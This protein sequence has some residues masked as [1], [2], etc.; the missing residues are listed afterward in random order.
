MK[1]AV[2]KNP[3]FGSDI[4]YFV[5]T[6]AAGELIPIIGM[7]GG[8]KDQPK[9]LSDGFFVQEDNVALEFNIPICKT[10]KDFVSA[11][12]TGVYLTKQALP[13]GVVPSSMVS[14]SFNPAYLQHPKAMEFGCEPDFNAWT[15]EVNPRPEA[16]DKTLRSCGGH[17]HV[18]WDNPDINTRFE[19][20]K[21]LDVFVGLN[22]LT[23]D[24]DVGRRQLYGK[25]GAMR[26]KEYGMEYRTLS[27][28]WIWDE[29]ITE[30]VYNGIQKAIDFVNYGHEI[31][32]GDAIVGAINGSNRKE[33]TQLYNQYSKLVAS[34]APKVDKTGDSGNFV[35]YTIR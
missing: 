30:K 25:A 28:A 18:G 27:N 5:Q 34:I 8:T 6:R 24:H 23:W 22:S 31:K 20:A 2:I 32:D 4:E 3:T 13:L 26:I 19:L 29:F 14:A 7:V 15:R 9:P 12:A 21:A 16:K 10:R 33:A 17:I 11:V 1:D 35:T